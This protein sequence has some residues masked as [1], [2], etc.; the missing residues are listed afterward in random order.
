MRT[1]RRGVLRALAAGGGTLSMGVLAPR[2]R[3]D[4]A[5]WPTRPLTLVV[6]WA[7]G[8]GTDLVFRALA[9]LL[10]ERL[11]QPVAVANRPGGSGT[12]GH[13]AIRTA[14]P[15]GTTFGA[16]SAQ[17]LTAP[18]LG[19]SPLT[20][21]DLQ[22]L[23]LVNV[24]AAAFT[25]RA[26]ASWRDL[27]GLVEHARQNPETVRVGNSGPGG[28]WHIASL[29]LERQA[30]IR[31][32]HAPY[33]GA[34]PGIRDMLGGHIDA[35]AFSAVEARAP[36]EGGQARIL[37][38]AAAQR[39]PVFPDAPTAVEQGYPIDIGAWRGLALPLGVPAPI[40]RR[41]QEVVGQAVDD[42]RFRSF[43][44]G[45]GFGIRHLDAEGVAAF[46]EQQDAAYRRFFRA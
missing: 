18:L 39:L 7:P 27:A 23:A 26:D 44:D 33:A 9:P 41:L 2:E 42:S 19:P 1:T 24:D 45:Q 30:G 40:V 34:A 10:S 22:P 5:D 29:E 37:A 36:V 31:L 16:I 11:G 13:M 12:V 3:A 43:I 14:A 20:W 15:D 25:V 32:I 4:A 6:P 21:R 46:L 8:G 35:V 17:L 28:T 38:V